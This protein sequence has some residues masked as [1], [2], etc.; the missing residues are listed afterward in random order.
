MA[1]VISAVIMEPK[2]TKS[3]TASNSPPSICHKVLEPDAMFLGFK[4]LIFQVS[5]FF[6]LLSSFTLIKRLFNFSSLSAIR[7]ASPTY[8]RLLIFLLPFLIPVCDSSILAFH[9]M[10]S[11]QKLNKKQGDNIQPCHNPLSILNQAQ[12]ILHLFFQISNKMWFCNIESILTF[13]FVSD[14]A[15]P[16]PIPLQS[17][18][19]QTALKVIKSNL[20]VSVFFWE[21]ERSN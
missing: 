10:Y 6:F 11:A 14:I 20:W 13:T 17:M 16:S 4:M 7:V 2:R 18:S 3:V 15:F 19:H 21:S 5:F 12:I 9:M 8:L 1:T